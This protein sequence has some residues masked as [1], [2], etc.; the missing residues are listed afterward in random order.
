MRAGGG[1][2]RRTSSVIDGVRLV[3]RYIRYTWRLLE[4]LGDTEGWALTWDGKAWPFELPSFLCFIYMLW[5][6]LGNSS[7][8][9]PDT[10]HRIAFQDF[11]ILLPG[12]SARL[13]QQAFHK[14]SIF[15]DHTI[16]RLTTRWRHPYGCGICFGTSDSKP[17]KD[18]RMIG[19]VETLNFFFFLFF[20]LT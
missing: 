13:L 3:E 20:Q 15:R 19:L 12:R 14:W 2:P 9:T 10:Y 18:I 6:N 7:P 5:R 16:K 17:P 8:R 11:S 4:T 1:G